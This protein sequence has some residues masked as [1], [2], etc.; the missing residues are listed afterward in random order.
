M[1]GSLAAGVAHEVGNPMGA[2]LA[3]LDLGA[4][5]PGL[6][7]ES[8]HCLSR[9]AEQGER[10]HVILRQLLDFSRAPQVQHVA[11]SLE[12]MGGRVELDPNGS[13]LGGARFGFVLNSDA[14][15]SDYAADDRIG[16]RNQSR[17]P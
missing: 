2:L 13:E 1:V 4:R 6:G 3:F 14:T 12:E 17:M 11:I 16:S 15:S 7:E 10:V 5:D 9:A 8:R